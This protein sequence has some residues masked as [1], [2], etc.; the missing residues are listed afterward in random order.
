[1]SKLAFLAVCLAFPVFGIGCTADSV[2]LALQN[3][4]V[5]A[6]LLFLLGLATQ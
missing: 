5:Q 3:S 4:T 6:A 2:A 1:M